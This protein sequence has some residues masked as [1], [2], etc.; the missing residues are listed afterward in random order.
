M[1]AQVGARSLHS[2]PDLA[3]IAWCEP[4]GGPFG[5][6]SATSSS[7]PSPLSTTSAD[8]DPLAA[9]LRHP[10][11]ET[12]DRGRGSSAGTAPWTG[13]V[14]AVPATATAATTVLDLGGGGGAAL[15]LAA[16]DVP[17]GRP[18]EGGVHAWAVKHRIVSS[19]KPG[20]ELGGGGGDAETLL[21]G[22]MQVGRREELSSGGGE[23]HSCKVAS[24]VSKPGLRYGPFVILHGVA[25]QHTIVHAVPEDGAAENP[26]E[27]MNVCE[28]SSA[29]GASLVFDV[30]FSV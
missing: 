2:R 15:F 4:C 25:K 27:S 19:G 12:W 10:M 16:W 3:N 17:G 24:R 21:G 5:G 20:S 30:R 8:D 1:N 14:A 6:A 9:H 7:S 23:G 28:H 22:D 11:V 13:P 26:I 18:M 29:A